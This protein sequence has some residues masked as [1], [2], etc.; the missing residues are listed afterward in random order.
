MDPSN[1]LG[2]PDTKHDMSA[3]FLHPFFTKFNFN[4]DITKQADMKALLVES[5]TMAE[6][7]E[8]L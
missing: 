5:E 8:R 1:R 6:K 4:E 3:V 7:Q 2:M